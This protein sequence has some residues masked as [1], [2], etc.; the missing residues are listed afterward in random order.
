MDAPPDI[1][2]EPSDANGGGI[3]RRTSLVS[4]METERGGSHEIFLTLADFAGDTGRDEK[5]IR[6]RSHARF[7]EPPQKQEEVVGSDAKEDS[8]SASP[9]IAGPPHHRE[10]DGA[11]RRRTVYR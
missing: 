10:D 2:A 7:Q 3:P 4:L 9:S 6:E 5:I 8:P 1:W 11:I